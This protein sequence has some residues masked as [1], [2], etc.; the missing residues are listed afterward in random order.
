VI[1]A[2]SWCANQN[3]ALVLREVE[4]GNVQLQ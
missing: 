2:A 1:T 3:V 4:G